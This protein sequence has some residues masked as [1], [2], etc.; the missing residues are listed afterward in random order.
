MAKSGPLHSITDAE[1]LGIC[2]ALDH[3]SSQTD[4]TRALIT[5]DSQT[6]LGQLC[7]ARWGRSRVTVMVVYRLVQTLEARGHEIRFFW[8]LGHAG[9]AGNESADALARAVVASLSLRPEGWGVSRAM[10]EG[11][12]RRWFQ[13]RAIQQERALAKEVLDLMEG[14]IIRSDLRWL[15][16]MPSRFMAARVGQFLSG[17]FPT[18]KYLHRFG[19]LPTPLC[20]CCGVVDM[21]GHLLL[22]CRRWELLCQ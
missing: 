16:A 2:L 10:V 15:R 1:L 19:H 18:A 14:T 8:A 3:L 12:L 17:H 20:E 11:A 21:R 5:S 7:Q 22:E 9:I 4:W 13:E 6:A